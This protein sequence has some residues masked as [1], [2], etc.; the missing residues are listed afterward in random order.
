M[1][2]SGSSSSGLQWTGERDPDW[3]PLSQQLGQAQTAQALEYVH[4]WEPILRDIRTEFK[5]RRFGDESMSPIIRE[6]LQDHVH[7]RTRIIAL[8][9]TIGHDFTNDDGSARMRHI[10]V[11]IKPQA[12]HRVDARRQMVWIVVRSEPMPDD[13]NSNSLMAFI[14]EEY[15]LTRA[16]ASGFWNHRHGMSF[17][18][19]K[20]A[21]GPQT[22]RWEVHEDVTRHLATDADY[23]AHLFN[24]ELQHWQME[25]IDRRGQRREM[26]LLDYRTPSPAAAKYWGLH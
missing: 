13:T 11:L 8:M 12:R 17:A 14:G 16:L 10:V 15:F 19:I 6:A 20:I 21:L 26:Q 7:S 22:N 3:I 1:A 25:I 9:D 23:L 5:G 4:R 24:S 2:D 18:A